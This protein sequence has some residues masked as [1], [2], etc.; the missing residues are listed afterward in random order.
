M[1]LFSKNEQVA[2]KIESMNC[3]HCEAKVSTAL[4][5]IP[6]V[7]KVDASSKTKIATI[8]A[9]K[10]QEPDHATIAKALEG[11]GYTAEPV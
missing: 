8:F 11:S 2:V 10:G 6:G 4:S 3:G 5:A 7:E 9:R 1:G